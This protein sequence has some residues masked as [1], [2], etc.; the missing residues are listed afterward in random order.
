VPTY[1]YECSGCGR[2]FEAFQRITEPPL[3]RCPQCGGAVRRLLGP[4]AFI[5]KG[6]GW[7]VTDYPSEARKK[8][9]SEEK[10]KK[11]APAPASKPE[12]SPSGT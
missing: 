8:A 3:E 10:E 1:E 5:L 12:S 2:S 7:Y 11:S 9:M 6:S 4:A